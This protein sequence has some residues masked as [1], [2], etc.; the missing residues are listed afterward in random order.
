[1]F[2]IVSPC[3]RLSCLVRDC[4]VWCVI[5]LRCAD[6]LLISREGGSAAHFSALMRIGR[7]SLRARRGSL[8]PYPHFVVEKG[9]QPLNRE[10]PQE[11][12]SIRSA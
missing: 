4:F 7:S 10:P 2:V 11:E 1:L 9:N 6:A 5:V 3:S 8:V 12:T